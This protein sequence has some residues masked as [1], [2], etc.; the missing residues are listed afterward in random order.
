[1][2]VHLATVREQRARSRAPGG[3]GNPE[4]LSRSGKPRRQPHNLC[5]PKPCEPRGAADSFTTLGCI[6][7]RDQRTN[8]RP[9]VEFA[10]G[11]ERACLPELEA[12]TRRQPAPPGRGPLSEGGPNLHER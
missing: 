1:M 10:T 8:P 5:L 11:Q 9:Q 7:R 4:Y 12:D 6:G 3:Q 2:P